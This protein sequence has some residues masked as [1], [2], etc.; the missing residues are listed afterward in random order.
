MPDVQVGMFY[1]CTSIQ[2]DVEILCDKTCCPLQDNSIEQEVERATR[3]LECN[4]VPHCLAWK[5]CVFM[6]IRWSSSWNW[7]QELPSWTSSWVCIPSG[8][9][10]NAF[11][12]CSL[13]L[14]SLPLLCMLRFISCILLCILSGRAVSECFVCFCCS[15]EAV[16]SY[17]ISIHL[18]GFSIFTHDFWW[19]ILWA[20]FR[21]EFKFLF[22]FH[23]LHL[24]C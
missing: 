6:I 9:I 20:V 3:H 10:S 2:K 12:R 21:T 22:F 24:P 4:Q 11:G 19:Y 14:L 1:G 13:Q 15:E 16:F 8:G 18:L 5:M 23:L 17:C 7:L